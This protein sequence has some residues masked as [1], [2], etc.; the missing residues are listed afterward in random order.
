MSAEEIKRRVQAQFGESGDAYVVSPEHRAG[1]DLARLVALAEL[2]PETVALDVATGGGHTGLALAPHVRQVT[3][4][5]LTPAMLGRARAFVTEQGVTNAA[6]Q[7]AD[8]EDLPFADGSFDL[9]TCRIAPHHFADVPR[10]VHEVARVL[11]P[12][13]LF[14]M[15]DNIA[16][17]E[18]ELDAFINTLEQRRDPSHI[19]CYTVAEW[20][21]YL[22]DAGLAVEVSEIF[23]RRH[24]YQEWTARSRM[25]PA[26]R[27]SLE[28]WVRA[29]SPACYERFKLEV[30]DGRLVAFSGERV[31]LKA[32]KATR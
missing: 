26:D 18:P 16:P 24:T 7:I 8:A 25:S 29:A 17:E 20:T 21:A 1:E 27:E 22:A 13:G 10:F 2:R 23:A 15:I 14:L 31:L 19:R 12:G 3:F 30:A 9:V 6:F 4:S 5:D 28:S 11:R 32:R